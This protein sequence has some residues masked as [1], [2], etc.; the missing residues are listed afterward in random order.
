VSPRPIASISVRSWLTGPAAAGFADEP[1]VSATFF[2][3]EAPGAGVEGREFFA[4]PGWDG[5]ADAALRAC[6][7]RRFSVNGRTDAKEG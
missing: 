7:A 2:G 4:E 5:G 3:L 6:F 1:A